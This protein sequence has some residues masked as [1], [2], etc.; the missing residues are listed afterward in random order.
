MGTGKFNAGGNT[1]MDLHPIQGGVEILH[2]PEISAS[3]MG[4]ISS[5]ADVTLPCTSHPVHVSIQRILKL[6]TMNCP[7][8]LKLDIHV[9]LN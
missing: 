6:L 3:L 2:K 4:K 5:Y 1:A 8:L 9:H 7:H